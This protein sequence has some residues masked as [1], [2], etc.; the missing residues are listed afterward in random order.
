VGIYIRGGAATQGADFFVSGIKWELKTL[1]SATN[2]AVKNNIKKALKQCNRVIIDGRA[3][4][5]SKEEAL[6]GVGRAFG[7]D[8]VPDELMIILKDGEILTW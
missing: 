8:N 2:E 1:D 6:R 7:V 3:V 4:G 5:L